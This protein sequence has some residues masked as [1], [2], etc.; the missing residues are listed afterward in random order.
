[1]DFISTI[2]YKVFHLHK[3]SAVCVYPEEGWGLMKNLVTCSSPPRLL[4]VGGS[5]EVG[6]QASLRPSK[7]TT[8]EL[9]PQ[10]QG[11][12]PWLYTTLGLGSN[13]FAVLD[14]QCCI[15]DLLYL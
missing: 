4:E 10:F 6:S 13:Q 7:L 15:C 1:M 2:T 8:T 14:K 3:V 11:L 12:S 5:A 9:H